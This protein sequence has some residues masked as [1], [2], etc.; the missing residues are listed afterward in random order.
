LSDTDKSSHILTAAL[1][2]LLAF[3]VLFS[4]R[5][6]DDN[7]LTSW[8]W[9]FRSVSALWVYAAL[10]GGV[11]LAWLA[12]R[13]PEPGLPA[14]GALSFAAASLFWGEPEVV[15][16]ASRYFTQAKHLSVYG[17]GYFLRE[18]GGEI[19]AWTDLPLVPFIYGLGFK[20]FGESRVVVQTISTAMFSGT[21][22]LT[23]LIGRELWDREAGLSAGALLMAM[24]YL[25]TQVPLM[26]VDVP[27]MF[28]LAL[29]LYVFMLAVRR[30]GALRAG[31]ASLAIFCVAFSKYSLWLMLSV[32]LVAW[33][34]MLLEEPR[35]AF[36]RGMAVFALAAALSLAF[37]L[38]KFDVMREQIRLLVE[39]QRPGLGRWVEGPASTFLFQI[40]PFVTLAALC[41][42]FVAAKR[43]DSK[44]LVALILPALLAAMGVWRIRYLLPA[45]PMVALMAGYGLSALKD[46]RLRRYVVSVSVVSS[47]LLAALAFL[48]FLSG[49]NAENMKTAG[50]YINSLDADIVTVATEHMDSEVNPA[51]AVPLLDIFVKKKIVY[52]QERHE[53]PG[54]LDVERSPLRFTWRYRNPAY[55]G[56]AETRE[57]EFMAVISDRRPETPEG[58]EIARIF[59]RYDGIFRFRTFVTVYRKNV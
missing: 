13:L 38:Y 39:Y 37:A 28:F 15:V 59:D 30:G 1:L 42:A 22:V 36:K 24:P 32:L 56:A 26:L 51:V 55:Y 58:Y 34:V 33:G 5:G 43:R 50:S 6:L 44:Y 40:H 54:S 46:S 8:D 4:L 21:V 49:L 52:A 12:L 23:A 10:S 3:A 45:F 9:V 7:R 27:S 11:L 47:V 31:A 41:S 17:A 48:P 29:A 35:G 18:W 2:S 20:A 16:D 53:P 57:G 14:L 25:Y 19:E